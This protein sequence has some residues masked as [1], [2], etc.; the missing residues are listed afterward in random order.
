MSH[1]RAP[2]LG[3]LLPFGPGLVSSP[4][5]GE[6]AGILES[7]G[8]ESVWAV[9]HVVVAAAYE[10]NY[11]YSADGRMPSAPGVVPMP[12]PLE[13]L[14]HLAAT[15]E[16]LLLG[17]CVVV[18][19]LHSPAVLAKRVA[20]LDLLSGGRFLLGLGIGWQPEE[21]AAVGVPFERRGER[22]EECVGAMRALWADHPATYEGR[23][24]SFR[25]VHLT[26]APTAGSVPVILG[27][28]SE[29]AIRRAGRIADGWFPYTIGPEEL[30]R[31]AA[32]LRESAESA[33]RSGEG[34]EIT[35][36]PGSADSKRELD[37]AWIRQF[38]DAGATRII[39]RPHVSKP[40]DL[41]GLSAQ[42]KRFRSVLVAAVA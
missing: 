22:L 31:G 12:D 32:L 35:V 25:D 29:P 21:Y 28:N 40:A 17:T 14:S 9:E 11:P 7:E 33:G 1:A 30:A 16:R 3:M 26:L 41:Q 10:P 8:V 34:I 2:K 37:A 27:G 18:A 19:P 6:F 13:V 15:T 20:T 4:L 24:V 38:L 42:L 23:T 36:W 5:L 39:T